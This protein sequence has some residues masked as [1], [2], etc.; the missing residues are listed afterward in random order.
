MPVV[1]LPYQPLIVFYMVSIFYLVKTNPKTSKSQVSRLNVEQKIRV[2]ICKCLR[3]VEFLPS[4]VKL[5]FTLAKFNSILHAW[6]CLWYHT[7][8]PYLGQYK[9]SYLCRPAQGG[10][11]E[12]SSDMRPQQWHDRV[13]WLCHDLP[14]PLW[15]VQQI[16]IGQGK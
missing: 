5:R 8:L 6:Y 12:Y 3:L 7:F 4:S 1:S 15:T 2:C 16:S 11:G 14:C 13:M 9:Q 10:K